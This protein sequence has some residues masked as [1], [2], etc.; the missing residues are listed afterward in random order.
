MTNELTPVED[1][2]FLAEN[3]YRVP[4]V[5]WQLKKNLHDV[6]KNWGQSDPSGERGT[7]AFLELEQDKFLFI[8][9]GE[10]PKTG[11][12]ELCVMRGVIVPS[13]LMAS[14]PPT[15]GNPGRIFWDA[16]VNPEEVK[17]ALKVAKGIAVLSGEF[18]VVAKKRL[19]V[20]IPQESLESILQKQLS[21]LKLD[22]VPFES[23]PLEVRHTLEMKALALL[24]HHL[25][26]QSRLK[27]SHKNKLANCF[28]TVLE[29][30]NLTKE[31]FDKMDGQEKEV[32]FDEASSQMTRLTQPGFF[33]ESVQN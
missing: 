18:D 30:H 33:A 8:A 5:S 25:S 26:V 10:D 13:E 16:R 27:R 23:L 3:T 20:E 2:Q 4:G 19:P 28:K 1:K 9:Q 12:D 17:K 14:I 15:K 24:S 22:T 32:I 7:A 6:V 11:L 31:E 29:H 21:N